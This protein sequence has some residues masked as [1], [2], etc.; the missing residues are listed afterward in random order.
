MVKHCGC[1]LKQRVLHPNRVW[2]QD[3]SRS[4]GMVIVLFGG[5]VSPCFK[6]NKFI[7]GISQETMTFVFEYTKFQ[8]DKWESAFQV[9][10]L[11]NSLSDVSTFVLYDCLG[12]YLEFGGVATNI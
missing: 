12:L 7:L 8:F 4:W 10:M 11:K 6:A 3:A 9:M 5:I 2:H 1:F